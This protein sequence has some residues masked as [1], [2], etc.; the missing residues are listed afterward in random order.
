L[1]TASDSGYAANFITPTFLGICTNMTLIKLTALAAL[2]S[3][4][5]TTHA[6]SVW[7]VSNDTQSLYIGGT[8][9]LL[10]PED[11]PLPTEY[12]TAFAQADKVVFETDMVAV[13]SVEFQQ[14]M[15]AS[16]MYSDGTTVDKVLKT[17]T[18]AA[19]QQH[20]AERNI[21]IEAMASLKPSLIAV[22][23]SVIEMQA[24]GFTSEG[25]DQ[26]YSNKA[27]IAG[28][29]QGWLETPEQQIAFLADLG[30]EDES[31]MIDYSLRDIKKMP[32]MINDLRNSWRDGDMQT[33]A[34]VAIDSFKADYPQIYEDLLVAR[35]QNWLPQ[36][37]TMLGDQAVE[38]ILVGALHLAGPDSVLTQL[39]A[40][41]YKIEKL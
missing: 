16:L 30:K 21:P 9:H 25:V 20:L 13:N 41:G 33:M 4:T 18:Y 14:Q 37:E 11:Y 29:P 12:D 36:I 1:L 40:K 3:L 24:L 17:E 32:T 5:F 7:K 38:F 28:K 26:F 15:F 34:T 35:N 22:T 6:A 2:A 31:G 10:A 27:T 8:I 39:A 19:L 23:L